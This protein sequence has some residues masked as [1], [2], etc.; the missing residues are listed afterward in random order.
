MRK[1]L[2]TGRTVHKL[3]LQLWRSAATALKPHIVPETVPGPKSK[4]LKQE[5]TSIQN[6]VLLNFFVDYEKSSGNYLV[7]VDGNQ[8]LDAFAQISSMPLVY[9]HPALLQMMQAEGAVSKVINRPALG[10]FPLCTIH[11]SLSPPK[12][13][14]YGKCGGP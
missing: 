10:M 3:G 2:T 12:D 9:N 7:D 8:I 5:L 13:E 14:L 4:E 11:S 6:T 1:S